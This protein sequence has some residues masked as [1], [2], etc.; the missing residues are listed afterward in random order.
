MACE[1]CC[2]D[3]GLQGQ[4]VD[5]T[6]FNGQREAGLAEQNR[7]AGEFVDGMQEPKSRGALTKLLRMLAGPN[8][9]V[10]RRAAQ[11]RLRLTENKALAALDSV[12]ASASFDDRF[13]AADTLENW[14]KGKRL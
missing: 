13:A 14:R 6:D 12:V 11:G 3:L 4:V 7:V 10:R 2:S 1:D 9:A 8:L 5:D